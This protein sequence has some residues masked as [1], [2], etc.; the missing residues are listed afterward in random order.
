[1]SRQY[2]V[3]LSNIYPTSKQSYHEHHDWDRLE[4]LS[5]NEST[6]D[7]DIV[8]DESPDGPLITPVTPQENTASVLR[9]PSGRN[10]R[11]PSWLRSGDYV[12]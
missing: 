8:C 7:E 2:K 6:D 1:M 11:P 5:S 9:P 3:P 4:T 10:R 12:T